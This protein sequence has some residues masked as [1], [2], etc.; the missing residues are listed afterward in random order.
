[1]SEQK[2][3]FPDDHDYIFTV[4]D[5]LLRKH[6]INFFIT[7][8]DFDVLYNW[9]DKKI[10]LDIVK[11]SIDVVKKRR[12]KKGKIIDSF[13]NFSY[14]VRKNMS[15]RMEL[16]INR[17]NT[18]NNKSKDERA[19]RFFTEFPLDLK[20]VEKE[21]IRLRSLEGDQKTELLDEV[22]EIII[23]E[24]SNDEEL[25]IKTEIFM[26]NLPEAMKNEKIEKKF[27]INYLNKRFG[28]P[29]NL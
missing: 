20:L 19:E 6:G 16:S 13:L 22:Y 15:E 12:Q 17:D 27:K 14:E 9:W 4:I 11:A 28:I 18:E 21:F 24:F 23:K 3:K 2:I 25:N 26:S 5:Y 8:K 7:S 10:P 29:E 1:M